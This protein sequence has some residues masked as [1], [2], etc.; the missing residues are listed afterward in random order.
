MSLCSSHCA[1][2]AQWIKSSTHNLNVKIFH[3]NTGAEMELGSEKSL[4]ISRNYISSVDLFSFQAVS[5]I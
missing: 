5:I 4:R 3:H 1:A 2:V